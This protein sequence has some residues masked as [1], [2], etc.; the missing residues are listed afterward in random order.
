LL[1]STTAPIYTDDELETVADDL[2]NR[3]SR[4]LSDIKSTAVFPYILEPDKTMGFPFSVED[5]KHYTKTAMYH[6]GLLSP[7]HKPEKNWPE[8][9]KEVW[10]H[11]TYYSVDGISPEQYEVMVKLHFS[12]QVWTHIFEDHVFSKPDPESKAEG[13]VLHIYTLGCYKFEARIRD[14]IKFMAA[15]NLFEF[16]QSLRTYEARFVTLHSKARYK[17]YLELLNIIRH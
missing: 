12:H 10:S 4:D 9:I 17:Y 11:L 1:P 7:E 14:Y 3:S 5:N 8:F 13:T 16:C 6:P 15:D 2:K